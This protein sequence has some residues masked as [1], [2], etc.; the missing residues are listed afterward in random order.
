MAT[1]KPFPQ[2]GFLHQLEVFGESASWAASAPLSPPLAR[3]LL[4]ADGTAVPTQAAFHLI[5][6]LQARKATL[7]AA[8]D[9]E[10]AAD[11]L[12]QHQKFARPGQPS[13]HVVQLRQ[14][15]AAARQAASVSRQAFVQAAAAFVREVGIVV[16]PRVALELYVT[17][18]IDA[19]VPADVA[20]TA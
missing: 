11:A 5:G 9:T 2:A 14:K 8:C 1:P 13:P 10:L 4:A 15:Q 16:P 7:Q 17:R 20:P 18:W 6:L 19:N 3:M 12:R